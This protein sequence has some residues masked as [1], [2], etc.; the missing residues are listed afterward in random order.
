MR[1]AIRVAAERG[2]GVADVPLPALAAAVGVSRSTLVRRLGG[3][4]QALEAAVR[5]A[6]VDPGGRVP[7][8]RR[9]ID[10]ATRLI[11]EQGVAAMT[12]EAVA[13]AAGCSVHSLFTTFGGRDGLLAAVYESYTPLFDIEALLDQPG[14]NL[15]Q[16]VNGMYR[17]F[18]AGL[19]R[20]PRVAPMMLADAF[21]RPD[22]AAGRLVQRYFPRALDSLGGWLTAEVAAGRIQRL[23]VAL[24]LHQ[25]LG[26]FLLHLLSGPLIARHVGPEEPGLDEA[27]AMFA[28]AFVRAV[29]TSESTEPRGGR[30]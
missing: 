23:P 17:A 18:A 6:G 19:S 28:A 2:V 4:R 11:S 24:L 5:A 15:E 14:H 16:T 25:L 7:V 21:A 29:G 12:L 10:A 8:R 3:S 22:G 20:E 9:A 13:T 27:C 30:T 1:A 26:P